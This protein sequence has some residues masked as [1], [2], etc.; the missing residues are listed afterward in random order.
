M[1]DSIE[2]LLREAYSTTHEMLKDPKLGSVVQHGLLISYGPPIATPDLLLL[3][4]Q[5]GGESPVV[6]ETWPKRLLYA[7]DPYKFGT[8]L[9]GLFQDTGLS[10]SLQS[11]AMA[12]PAVFP[13]APS[14]EAGR[15]MK[16]TGP[17]ANWRCHSAECVERLVESINP[18]VVIVFGNKTSEV[19]DIRWEKIERIHAQGHQTFGVST[20]QRAPAVFCHH[21]SQGFVKSEALMCFRYAKGVISGRITGQARVD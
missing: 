8:I 5:G 1:S 12:F 19:F 14:R 11:S 6:Q 15:W 10:S 18:K 4:F 9:R 7:N 3:T 13:Q 17:H 16:K 20:F 2:A 21:L